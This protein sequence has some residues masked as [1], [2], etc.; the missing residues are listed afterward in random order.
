MFVPVQT[1]FFINAMWLCYRKLMP[2]KHK[3]PNVEKIFLFPSQSYCALCKCF[4]KYGGGGGTIAFNATPFCL[5]RSK[6][7]EE[8]DCCYAQTQNKH[9]K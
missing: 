8:N 9:R 4:V 7:F 3:H 1:N 2:A 5:F 6:Q